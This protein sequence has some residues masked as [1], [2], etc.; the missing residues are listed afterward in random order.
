MENKAL[1][2][3][4]THKHMSCGPFFCTMDPKPLW[5]TTLCRQATPSLARPSNNDTFPFPF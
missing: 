4:F 1:T 5:T 3:C 2:V